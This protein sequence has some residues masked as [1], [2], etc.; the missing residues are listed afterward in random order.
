[1]DKVSVRNI[2]S[3][4]AVLS[5]ELPPIRENSLFVAI[6]ETKQNKKLFSLIGSSL[7]STAIHYINDSEGSVYPV[8]AILDNASSSC[9]MSI[10]CA[11]F[12]H[13]KK[14][15]HKYRTVSRIN[16]SLSSI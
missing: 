6:G 3:Q 1:M 13:L 16:N 7:L 11:N 9:F 2:C 4:T 5:E 14:K 8:Q 10:E 15:E 12:L